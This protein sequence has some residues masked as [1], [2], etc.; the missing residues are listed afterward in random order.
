MGTVLGGLASRGAVPWRLPLALRTGLRVCRPSFVCVGVSVC[1]C[2]RAC[3]FV[4]VCA[5]GALEGF[6]LLG[7]VAGRSCIESFRI[8]SLAILALVTTSALMCVNLQVVS[9]LC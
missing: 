6:L 9:C 1:V 8:G 3:V 5:F 2:V 7:C 4:C